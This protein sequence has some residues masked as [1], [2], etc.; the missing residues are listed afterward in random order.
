MNSYVSL[1]EQKIKC[2]SVIFYYISFIL[3][4]IDKEWTADSYTAKK[5][6]R[7][8]MTYSFCF[9]GEFENSSL[10]VSKRKKVNLQKV[11][12]QSSL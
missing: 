6:K 1:L 9:P 12:E 2:F 8:L 3:R 11:K 4:M 10:S 7:F 5:K